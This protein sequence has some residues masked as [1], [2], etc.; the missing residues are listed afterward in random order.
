MADYVRVKEETIRRVREHHTDSIVLHVRMQRLESR[1]IKGEDVKLDPCVGDYSAKDNPGAKGSNAEGI[2]RVQIKKGGKG[3]SI[4][5]VALTEYAAIIKDI[6]SRVDWRVMLKEFM[7]MCG[8]MQQF[9]MRFIA[10]NIWNVNGECHS[11]QLWRLWLNNRFSTTM[12][13]IYGDQDV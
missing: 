3:P 11:G 4:S 2:D 10:V 13:R 5:E 12:K 8:L 6:D 9:I 1:R 7:T